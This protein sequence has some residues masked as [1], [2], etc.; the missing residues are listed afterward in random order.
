MRNVEV[1]DSMKVLF[2]HLGAE[3]CEIRTAVEKSMALDYV[4]RDDGTTECPGCH[5]VVSRYA[6]GHGK[7]EVNYCKWCGQHINWNIALDEE[8]S[9]DSLCDCAEHD[10]ECCGSCEL[11]EYTG[12]TE[13]KDDVNEFPFEK[14]NAENESSEADDIDIDGED[15]E[16]V[17]FVDG[18]DEEPVCFEIF[19]FDD[20][21]DV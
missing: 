12:A 5:H 14:V 21:D 17:C 15:E 10:H 16:P 19:E 6:K 9:D 18:E 4:T 20:G 8:D 13:E 7:H 1:I 3:L 11:C 2:P